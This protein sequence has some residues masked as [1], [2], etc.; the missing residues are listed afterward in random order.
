MGAINPVVPAPGLTDSI[1]TYHKTKQNDLEDNVVEE[2]NP[3]KLCLHGFRH[4][5]ALLT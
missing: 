5:V 1:N 2:S 3:L 4:E